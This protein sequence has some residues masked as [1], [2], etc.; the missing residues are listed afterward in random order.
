MGQTESYGPKKSYFARWGHDFNWNMSL[1]HKNQQHFEEDV[2]DLFEGFNESSDKIFE[3][4]I[5]TI[6]SPSFYTTLY[7]EKL[8]AEP[9]L[10]L[11]IVSYF[12]HYLHTWSSLL[13]LYDLG[14]VMNT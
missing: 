12:L 4:K 3:D 9:Q 2:K 11:A 14:N 8:L 5:Y 6:W 10:F 1:N 13:Q 7:L